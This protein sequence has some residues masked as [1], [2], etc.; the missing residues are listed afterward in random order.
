MSLCF[1][2]ELR[3]GTKFRAAGT[4]YELVKL[5]PGSALVKTG[6]RMVAITTASG[7]EIQFERQASQF[8]ISLG[9]EIDG[10]E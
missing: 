5:G 7:Q 3:P 4:E 2:R 9:T 6:P 10:E 8:T 1:V